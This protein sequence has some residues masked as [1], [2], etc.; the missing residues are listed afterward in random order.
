GSGAVSIGYAAVA[1]AKKIFGDLKGLNVVVLGAGEMGK[2]T[3]LHLKSQGAQHVTIVSRTMA[4]AARTAEAIGGAVAA[5]WDDMDT[6]LGNSDIVVTATG[7]S[8]P[9]LTKA[10]LESVMR[11]RRN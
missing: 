3:A 10:R 8:A 5:P 6:A 4:H 9:I 2:L 1:L 11:P 7:A